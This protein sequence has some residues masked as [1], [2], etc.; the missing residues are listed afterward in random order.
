MLHVYQLHSQPFCLAHCSTS[1]L[2]TSA[3]AAQVDSSH[4]EP[5][6]SRYHALDRDRETSTE[7]RTGV[8]V[9]QVAGKGRNKNTVLLNQYQ[10]SAVQLGGQMPQ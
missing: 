5:V 8:S 3:I 1:K 10:H 9:E 6:Q 2:P 7:E 4:R